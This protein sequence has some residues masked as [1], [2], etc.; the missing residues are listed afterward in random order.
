MEDNIIKLQITILY[1]LKSK[2][3]VENKIPKKSESEIK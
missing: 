2:I 3:R 1:V